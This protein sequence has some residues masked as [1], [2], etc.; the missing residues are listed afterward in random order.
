MRILNFIC[1]LCN[2]KDLSRH[3]EYLL[4]DHDCVI[5]PQLGA[6]I[7]K[8]VPSRW[9]DE[10]DLFLPPYRSISFNEM[11]KDGDD[12]FVSTLSKR[13][14]ITL[15]EART[16]CADFL[17]FI[18][19]ELTA[20]GSIDLGSIG[21]LTQDPENG[22]ISFSPCIAGV[23][24]PE[25]YG[26]DVCHLTP[27]KQEERID[28]TPAK[29][30]KVTSV[31]ADDKNITIRINRSIFN[32]VATI[33]AS[34]VL[35]FSL[36]TPVV[37]TEMADGQ[38]AE[39][40]LFIPNN[41]IPLQL[42]ETAEAPQP[43]EESAAVEADSESASEQNELEE[44]HNKGNFAI[45]LASAISQKNA[46]R[47]VESLKSKGYNAEIQETKKLIRVIIPGF[48]TREDVQVQIKKMKETS[49]EFSKI[50]T[51]EL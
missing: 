33:A 5:Y 30:V 32:Y 48:E 41:L 45:V 17:E 19:Q 22:K 16:L 20:N 13:Y 12:L 39:M 23:T 44:A 34:I 47:Y 37:N 14:K 6:F 50:W 26:L 36:T 29:N 46:E 42:G 9:V 43:V 51:L 40:N 15:D 25:L 27:I 35:F 1:Y 7:A 21:I 31:Q 10:E 2:M 49:A 3:I 11:L 38:T 24:S 28:E 4:L 18:H 8:Y